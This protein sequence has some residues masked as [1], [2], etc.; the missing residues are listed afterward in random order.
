M[1]D[2][3]ERLF[4]RVLEY[5]YNRDAFTYDEIKKEL[6]I[7][8]QED[9]QFQHLFRSGTLEN[10]DLLIVTKVNGTN[11]LTLSRSGE[12]IALDYLELR[13]ARQSARSAQEQ[14]NKAVMIAYRSMWI[15][16]F[17]GIAGIIAQY[18]FR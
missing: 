13:E 12:Q 8:A 7:S 2:K 6:K 1:T 14:G 5:A 9:A 15:S 10:P 18:C 4:T 16:G 3:K 17:I 11:T